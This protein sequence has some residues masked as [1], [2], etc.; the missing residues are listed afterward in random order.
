MAWFSSAWFGLVWLGRVW[1]GFARLVWVA[2]TTRVL[3]SAVPALVTA[4]SIGSQISW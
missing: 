3:L 1:F 2:R 4:P